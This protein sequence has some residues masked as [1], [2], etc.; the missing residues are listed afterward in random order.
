[1]N[2]PSQSQ[3]RSSVAQART[4]VVK[5]GSS[6][7]THA[8]GRLDVERL[9]ALVSAIAH[10]S[11][12]GARLVLVSSGA[13]AAGFGQLGFD[14][15]P[16]DVATQQATASV[17]Q[18]L[19]MA[20]YESSFGRFG[21]R[22][23]QILITAEDTIRATQY[24][25]ARRTLDRLLELGVV[26]IVNENDAL[27]SNEIRFGDN[28]RL[29][30]LVA[31]M[32]RADALVLLTDVDCLYTEP[33]SR[34]GARRIAYVP[35]VVNALDHV[36]VSGSV[37]GVGTG[38]MVTKL[39]ASRI[40][41][42]SGIPT[43]LTSADN[44]GPALMGDAVGTIFAPVRHRGSSRRLWISFAAEP[45]GGLTV[46]TGAA[47]AI[48]GGRASLLAAGV[49]GAHGDF[50]AGDPI[51][52]SDEAGEHIAKGLAGYDSEEVPHMLGRNTTQ[53]RRLLGEAYAHP[54]VHRDNLVLV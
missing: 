2:T 38:G 10:T 9:H 24:R 32:V 51:W 31:N 19:L 35:D 13:I 21:L 29:S 17:G 11:L 28:D 45:R 40:A 46:D 49:V 18:G 7:L 12:M 30:A 25:N 27:A 43:V 39:E 8:S 1:M 3:V 6:S 5:V 22:V 33:P 48:R 54:L 52:V 20:H 47:K 16:S 26:P 4:I 36:K 37:S 53:L 44:A 23:G 41:A 14:E 50:S 15:R 42:V 34:P